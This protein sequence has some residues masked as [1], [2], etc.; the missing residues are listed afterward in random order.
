MKNG[1][2]VL[3]LSLILCSCNKEEFKLIGKISPAADGHISIIMKSRT[4]MKEHFI[5]TVPL[6]EGEFEFH[7]KTIKPPVKLTFLVSDSSHFDVWIGEYGTKTI[8]VTK[9]DIYDIKMEGSFFFSEL[10]RMNTSLYNMYIKPIEKKEIEAAEI[11]E[12]EEIGYLTATS[13]IRL[14]KLSKSIKTAYKLRKKS[15]LKTVRKNKQNPVAVALMCQQYDR[16]TKHQKKECFKYL[17]KTF[18]DTGLNWQMN[19]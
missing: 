14:D 18:G 16:L 12:L 6:V 19:N 2:L 9:D 8:Q 15:I 13:Q 4:G 5:E 7:S 17:S 11:L 3:L 10:N 1:L